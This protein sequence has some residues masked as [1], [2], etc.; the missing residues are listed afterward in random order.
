MATFIGIGLA[1]AVGCFARVVGLDRER[2]FYATVLM[3]VASYYGLFAAMGGTARAVVLECVVIAGFVG[4]AVAGF[5]GSRWLLVAGLFAHGV[6]DSFHGR[7]IANAG[8]PAWWP[9]FCM[10]YD[11]T[12]AVWLA[13]LILRERGRGAESR[14]MTGA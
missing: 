12:A 8:V 5:R 7:V 11:V 13:G 14:G 6:Q 1:L 3:V 10:A 9:Q 4:V 2:G